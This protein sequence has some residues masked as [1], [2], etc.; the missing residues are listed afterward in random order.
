MLESIKRVSKEVSRELNKAWESLAD[1]WREILSRSGNAL[2]LFHR[3]GDEAQPQSATS[4]DYPR[5][6]LLTAEVI[7]TAASIIVRVEIPGVAKEDCR[8]TIEGNTLYIR[9]EKRLESREQ[10]DYYH[11]IE[12][13]YGSFQ[14]AVALP[15][16]VDGDRAEARFENGVLTVTL[17]RLDLP[18]G[19]RVVI[20]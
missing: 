19:K 9:G 2:T 17:P 4:R 12:R 16:A 3:A 15:Y 13:A 1:G 10:S 7:E 5:W 18:T 11:V 20:N 14:R 6:S 8:V